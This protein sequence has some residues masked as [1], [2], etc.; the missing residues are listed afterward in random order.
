MCSGDARTSVFEGAKLDLLKRIAPSIHTRLGCFDGRR[1]DW[2]RPRD[3]DAVSDIG[4]VTEHVTLQARNGDWWVG[5]GEGLY[6]FPPVNTSP[7][8]SRAPLAVY[9]TK[10][11]LA[12][13]QVFRLFEDLSRQR[14]GLDH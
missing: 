12:A 10:D 13:W 6:R 11:G 8:L 9:T 14:V 4:W 2:F 7:T 5:T 1:F 3:S